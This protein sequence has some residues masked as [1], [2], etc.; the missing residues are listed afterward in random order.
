MRRRFAALLLVPALMVGAAAC[1]DGKGDKKSS[2]SPSPT[3]P[4]R[5]VPASTTGAVTANAAFNQPPTIAVPDGAA[6]AGLQTTVLTE[7]TGPVVT[8]YDIVKANYEG[9]S[10]STKK[11]FDSSFDRGQPAEFPLLGVVKGWTQGLEGKKVGSRV[12]LV[13]PPD[14]GYGA[15]GKGDD[16]KAN[17]TLVFIVDIV[18]DTPGYASGTPAPANPD[19]PTLTTDGPKVSGITFPAGKNPPA[20]MVSQVLIEGGGAAITPTDTLVH[21]VVQWVWGDPKGLG[22][23]WTTSGVT[24]FSAA[25]ANSTLGKSIAE[26][27]AGK[28]VGSRVMLVIPPDKAF[29]AAGAP[30]YNIPANATLVIVIDVVQAIP[31]GQ[32]GS[33]SGS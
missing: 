15:A 3:K 18:S 27:L 26:G 19:L 12:Q 22:S 8:K 2:A 1:G 29:G 25:Q 33:G 30:Q 21:Q 17:E 4:A 31:A 24:E 5:V 13:I 28:K 11:V 23:S 7:G 9:V 32:A 20:Q 14:L 16:I 6:P 10:W